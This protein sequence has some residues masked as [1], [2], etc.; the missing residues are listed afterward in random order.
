MYLKL[1]CIQFAATLAAFAFL[2]VSSPAF[3]AEKAETKSVGEFYL[4][5]VNDVMDIEEKGDRVIFE[6]KN[7]RRTLNRQ[8]ESWEISINE[9]PYPG[10]D[11]YSRSDSRR[12][13]YTMQGLPELPRWFFDSPYADLAILVGG[14]SEGY[15]VYN[16]GNEGAEF[17]GIGIARYADSEWQKVVQIDSVLDCR[18]MSVHDK[19]FWLGCDKG[20]LRVRRDTNEIIKYRV[21]PYL[22]TLAGVA[23]GEKFDYMTTLDGALYEMDRELRELREIRIPVEK[24]PLEVHWPSTE[25]ENIYPVLSEPLLRKGKLYVPVMNGYWGTVRQNRKTALLVF[26]VKTNEWLCYGFAEGFGLNKVVGDSKGVWCL[27][28]W[29]RPHEGGDLTQLGGLAFLGDDDEMVVSDESLKTI[30]L[31]RGVRDCNLPVIG[32]KKTDNGA[33]FVQECVHPFED[34]PEGKAGEVAAYRQLCEGNFENGRLTWKCS[35]PQRSIANRYDGVDLP[36]GFD[37]LDLDKPRRYEMYS[38]EGKVEKFG[39]WKLRPKIVTQT[40]QTGQSE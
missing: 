34:V 19:D 11:I 2:S 26:D 4:M 30:E 20:I 16:L 13:Y 27:G 32:M 15:F 39:K 29:W 38:S 24:L 33:L 12:N 35:G 7:G 25:E 1:R 36:E 17:I 5:D 22:R 9:K 6:S 37:S 23:E 21:E 14:P 28:S 40:I 18:S 3:T 31:R 10:E 8:D